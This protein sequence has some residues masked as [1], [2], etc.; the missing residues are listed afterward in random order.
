MI[1]IVF[2]HACTFVCLYAY[3]E[4]FTCLKFLKLDMVVTCDLRTGK[5]EAEDCCK[6]ETRLD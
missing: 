2:A 1:G 3:C 5:A 4:H 6:L